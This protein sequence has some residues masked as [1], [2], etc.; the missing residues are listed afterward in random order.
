[1]ST[2]PTFVYADNASP[3]VVIFPGPPIAGTVVEFTLFF[4]EETSPG[5]QVWQPMDFAGKTLVARAKR[6]R[7]D[8]NGTVHVVTAT[9]GDPGYVTFTIPGNV[10]ALYSH[11]SWQFT[12]EPTGQPTLARALAISDFDIMAGI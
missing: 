12:V 6:N 9:P 10:T 7:Y 3:F 5:S 1:M 11:L 8:D 2:L 4:E